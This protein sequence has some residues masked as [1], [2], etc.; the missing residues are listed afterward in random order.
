MKSLLKLL[1]IILYLFPLCCLLAKGCSRWCCWLGTSLLKTASAICV[2]LCNFSRNTLNVLAQGESMRNLQLFD[3][4]CWGCYLCLRRQSQQK[5]RRHWQQ[6]AYKPVEPLL[7]RVRFFF[8]HLRLLQLGLVHVKNAGVRKTKIA[9]ECC[10]IGLSLLSSW[11]IKNLLKITLSGVLMIHFS[12]NSS[13]QYYT[14]TKECY[15]WD[16]DREQMT[17]R[18]TQNHKFTITWYE[19]Q[20]RPP[21]PNV[22]LSTYTHTHHTV[23]RPFSCLFTVTQ[24]CNTRMNA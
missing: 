11:F 8:F 17:G 1:N 6:H 14:V 21:K 3:E 16:E 15:R 22:P 20:T 7:S 12:D 10:W 2:V 9:C 13:V 23:E 24:R 19:P 4:S 5:S 18:I